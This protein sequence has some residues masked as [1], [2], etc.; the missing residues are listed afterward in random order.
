MGSVDQVLVARLKAWAVRNTLNA[1]SNEDLYLEFSE[2]TLAGGPL[3]AAPI[4]D[5]HR[6]WAHDVLDVVARYPTLRVLA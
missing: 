3:V 5:A 2:L 6:R 1:F 4:V